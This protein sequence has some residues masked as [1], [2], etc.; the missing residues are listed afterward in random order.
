MVNELAAG[1]EHL[2]DPEGKLQDVL[3]GYDNYISYVCKDNALVIAAVKVTLAA[4]KLLLQNMCKSVFYNYVGL[5]D[6]DVVEDNTNTI[7]IDVNAPSTIV[8]TFLSP[9]ETTRK[10]LINGVLYINRN[11][12]RYTATGIRVE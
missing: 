11:G 8:N 2:Y 1:D 4:P 10:E 12:E 9:D 6:T 3:T 7:L 5:D